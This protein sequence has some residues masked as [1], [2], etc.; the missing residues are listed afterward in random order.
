ME[1]TCPPPDFRA[2]V[3]LHE[4]GDLVG[5][6]TAYRRILAIDPGHADALHL[7]GVVEHQRGRHEVALQLIGRAIA[8]A[9]DRADYRNNLGVVLRALGR[10]E[11]AV[12]AHREAIRLVPAYPDA[13][14]NLGVA[15][16]ELG[17]PHEAIT[18]LEAAL[19]LEP[20]HVNAAFALADILRQ[21][22]DLGKALSLYQRAHALAPGRADVLNNLG[23]A[24]ASAGRT[25]EAADAFLLAATLDP[26]GFEPM[27]NHGALM[28][29]MGRTE[30]AAE[31]YGLVA[32]NRPGESHWP[33]RIAALC[34][35]I[36]TDV[37]AIG[38]YRVGLE[39]VLDAH[40]DGIG[41]TPG[42]EET[43]GCVPP[44]N[45]PHHG[46]GDRRIK[47]KF[48]AL[49]RDNF[50]ARR[51]E[52][53]EGIPRV[54]F[55]A[56]H[57]HH[58]G[59]LRVIGGIVERLEPG[60]FVPVILGTAPAMPAMQ[61]GIRRP[62][63]EF[64][65]IPDRPRPAA[66]RVAGARCDILYHWQARTDPLNYF[67]ARQRLAPVQCTS[68][69]SHETTGLSS[70][71]Y[72]LSSDWIEPEGA[73]EHYTEA[74]VRLPTFPTFESRRPRPDPPAARAEFGLPEGRHLYMCLQRL[75]KFH[76][77]F[78]AMLGGVLRGDPRGLVIALEDA[79]GHDA[80]RLRA[81]LAATIP[82]VAGRVLFLPR[83]SHPGYLRL[84]SLADVV[85]DTPHYSAGL[86]GH[87]ALSLGLPI[88]TLPGR[89]KVG[90]YVL[91]DYRRLGINDLVAASPEEYAILAT[92]LGTDCSFRE[93]LAG[94][95]AS[96]AGVLFE[97][98]GV[99]WEHERF[100]E[101]ALAAIRA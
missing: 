29:G 15:L 82:D 71:D 83:Q 32:R 22:G 75:A 7:L 39:A 41:L 70:I 84:L 80:A 16:Q 51:P 21:A 77:D 68:W 65:T 43:S 38:R 6:E 20:R 64:V 62:D 92:R 87:D 88:V 1:P 58:G 54:G 100:F 23:V 45:L 50:P 31:A 95:I 94:R 3:G 25:G 35:S 34:P 11:D 33:I 72:F 44:F 37:A 76:P 46:L 14:A 101:R 30:E 42:A 59:F 73:E 85:L 60:R 2:A 55:L 66:D 79:G 36:F 67:L 10:L 96:A 81:R 8:L 86:T 5:A 98:P 9:P 91:A 12:A 48:A 89:F 57:P 13:L 40:R 78:D 49:F 74:L 99:V 93:N 26:A 52:P 28:E 56:T 27:S 61:A 19:R 24:L 47:E 4:S 63:A 18:P 53:G 90:R 97:D 69:G 17:L